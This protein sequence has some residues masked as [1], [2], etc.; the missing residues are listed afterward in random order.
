VFWDELRL[1]REPAGA[2]SGG[3]IVVTTIKAFRVRLVSLTIVV[4]PSGGSFLR[5][6][7][8]RHCHPESTP[9]FRLKAGLRTLCECRYG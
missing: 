2:Q 1:S 9:N 7:L 6:R 4:P 5:L 3:A 8:V